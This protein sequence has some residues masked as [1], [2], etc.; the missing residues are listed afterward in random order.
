MKNNIIASIA[1]FQSLY[2]NGKLDIFSVIAKFVQ[3][4]IQMNNLYSFDTNQL[5]S[6]LK[7]DFEIE[8]P[9]SVIRTVL[10]KGLV[11]KSPKIITEDMLLI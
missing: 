8:I 5:K 3:S 4:T 9:E 11:M 1:L 7:N 10:K 6:Q 2:D